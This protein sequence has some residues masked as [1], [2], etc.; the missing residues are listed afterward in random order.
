M[1]DALVLETG[2]SNDVWVRFPSPVPRGGNASPF[3]L[4]GNLLRT[5]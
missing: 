3:C 2:I 1:V 5:L 4:T